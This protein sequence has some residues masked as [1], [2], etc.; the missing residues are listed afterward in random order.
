MRCCGLLLFY[1]CV[2]GAFISAAKPPPYDALWPD[3]WPGFLLCVGGAALGLWLYRHSSRCA[4]PLPKSGNSAE[5]PHALFRQLQQA[6]TELE[7]LLS[8]ARLSER[9]ETV[10]NRYCLTLSERHEEITLLLGRADGTQ[11]LLNLAQAERLLNRMLSA[12]SDGEFGEVARLYPLVRKVLEND[13][14]TS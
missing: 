1:A 6:V 10:L 5:N 12:A 2:L 14:F 4:V 3:T 8:D 13:C 11:C 9:L 7:P